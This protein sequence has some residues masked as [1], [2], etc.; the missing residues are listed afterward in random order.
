[1]ARPFSIRVFLPDGDP[2]GLRV[3][4]KSNWS[5]SGIVIPRALFPKG[6]GRK[7]VARA[8]V[9]VLVGSPEESELPRVYVGE[10]D[11]IRPRLEQHAKQKDFW[12]RCFAF[13][14]KDDNLNKAHV[15]YLESRLIEIASKARR[16]TLD[17]ANQPTLPSFSES[18]AADAEGFLEEMLLCFPVLGLSVFSAATESAA[19]A[20]SPD[21]FL[22]TRGTK[23]RGRETSEGMLVFKGSDAAR[24]LLPSAS[25]GLRRMHRSL[26]DN[27]VLAPSGDRFVFMQ[28]YVLNSPSLAAS[29]VTGRPTNGRTEWKT[30]EGVALKELQEA[31]AE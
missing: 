29:M 13:S 19:H 21:M 12:T 8:G 15:Q 2:D 4:E 30:R 11:P 17:N 3:I 28:D 26:V 9:Y 10:G 18:D 6:R 25:D 27:G 14:S 1:M 22:T 24:E 16:C 23:A 5:G 7:E 31:Q 20:A